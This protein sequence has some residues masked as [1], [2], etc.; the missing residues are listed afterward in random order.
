MSETRITGVKTID[1]PSTM[2]GSILTTTDLSRYVNTL[3]H[4]LFT[5][6]K[7]CVI[8]IDQ[9]ANPNGM[10]NQ[11]NDRHPIIC[12]LYFT[13]DAKS[14]DDKGIRAFDII[15]NDSNN[16]DEPK[17][18]NRMNFVSRME[19]FQMAMS[20]NKTSV[21]TQDAVDILK[22]MLWYE[23]K[24][25]LPNKCTP[26]VFNEKG[27]SVETVTTGTAQQNMFGMSTVNS[28]KTVYGVVRFVDINEILHLIF[29][30]D[31]DNKCYYEV[32][33]VRPVS[34]MYM[35][36]MQNMNDI[37]EQK[38]LLYVNKLNEKAVRDIL[39]ELGTPTIAGP[40]ISTSRF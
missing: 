9:S 27:I 7:G 36:M 31:E 20:D 3:F 40:N 18:K 22:G 26:K 12:D 35:N 17:K 34:S 14:K 4:Q 15:G 2:D 28:P 24:S 10:Q 6:Y 29:G 39:T 5:D 25:N 30:D 23:L 11:L 1:F 33:P 21:I 13:V 32:K 19:V 8:K 38:W 16:S 37:G